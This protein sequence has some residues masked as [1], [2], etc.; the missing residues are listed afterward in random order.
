[1]DLS[2][3]PFQYS[4]TVEGDRIVKT[5]LEP[6]QASPAAYHAMLV[7]E[8]FVNKSS[9]LEVSI[10]D[11]IKIRASQVN[12]CAFS[13]DLHSKKARENGETEQRLYAL[14]AWR[15]T[16]FFTNRERAALAW[17]EALT[18]I[19]EGRAPDEVYA[20]V[21]KQFGEEE[22]VNLSLAVI[23]INGWNRLAIGF[24]KIPGEYQPPKIV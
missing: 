2:V 6:A 18:L 5:R 15:E 11:L 23:T 22:L 4:L 9:K 1:M 19:T 24:R 17:T 13:I 21:R 10:L 12:G 7:L 8:N 16:S 14:S 3:T 20:D